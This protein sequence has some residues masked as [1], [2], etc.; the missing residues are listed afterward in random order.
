M[1]LLTILQQQA[2]KTISPNWAKTVK[3]LTGTTNY[4]QLAEEVERKQLRKLLGIT[5][6]QDVSKNPAT[7]QN[8]VLLD[9]GD[10]EDCNGNTIYFEGLRYVLAYMNYSQYIG[11][12]FVSDSFAGMVKKDRQESTALNANERRELKSDAQELALSEWG[13]VE[14]FLNKNK[15]TYTLWNCAN[16]QQIYPPRFQRY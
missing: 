11:E 10:Y 14:A 9:G 13:L 3:Q 12:S 15:D 6:Y 1:S 16:T 5:L 8:V 4:D 7:P 2:I